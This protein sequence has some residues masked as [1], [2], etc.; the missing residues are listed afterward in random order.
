MK[1]KERIGF[2][3]K[4]A[5]T[6][7]GPTT[8]TTTTP[9][10]PVV[11]EKVEM[12][13]IPNFNQNLFKLKP[14]FA[15]D[16]VGIFNFLNKYIVALSSGKTKITDVWFAP[17]RGTSEFFGGLKNIYT[18]AKWLYQVVSRSDN[19]YSIETLR[20]IVKDLSSMV[21]GMEFPEQ[22]ATNI[23]S[24]LTN[25]CQTLSNKLG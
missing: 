25:L 12:S 18:I 7:T 22:Q 17:S 3:R 24:E 13:Q 9:A 10:T 11:A 4:L 19:P 8:T 6:A 20:G 15:Q 16:L 1:I 5:Q 23:K 14:E 2:W 21:Q